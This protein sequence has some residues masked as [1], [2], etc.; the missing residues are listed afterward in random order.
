MFKLLWKV[1]LKDLAIMLGWKT[2]KALMACEKWTD[3]HKAWQILQIFFKATTYALLEP[4][5][6]NCRSNKTAPSVEGL[7]LCCNN[8]TKNYMFLFKCTF[9]YMF[10]LDLFRSSVRRANFDIMSVC[11]HKF[12]Q[13]F[14]GLNMTTYMEITIRVDH[15]LQSA[16]P[17]VLQFIK[18]NI[19]LSQ[20]GHPSKGEGGDFILESVNK[21]IKSWMP[22]GVPT[23][24]RWLRVCRN[25]NSMEKIKVC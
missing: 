4:Y 9:T 12:S 7:Y 13:L 25:L 23:E 20:S 18:D 17:E 6:H 21:K 19:C 8:Q 5:V 2:L 14:Y 10:A 3:H 22:P 16:P 24:Q 1:C 15:L 11:L